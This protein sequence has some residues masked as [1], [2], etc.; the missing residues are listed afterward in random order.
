MENAANES[1]WMLE[2]VT[3][4]DRLTILTDGSRQV[5]D[6]VAADFKEMIMRRCRREPFQYIVGEQQ[7]CG[8][9]FKVTPA[10]LIPRFE[11]E[12]L[13]EYLASKLGE[14]SVGKLL[15]IGTG[16][17]CIPI[18]LL[19]RLEKWTGVTVDLSE[20]A[21]EV[22]RKNM[23]L[24]LE[25]GQLLLLHGDCFEP[26]EE[27]DYDLIVSNPPYIEREELQN[28]SREVTGYEP[29]MAL[30]G[31]EDGL[32]FY[33]KIIVEGRGY[34]KKGGLLAFEIGYNQK[35]PVEA[36]LE[37]AGY[38]EIETLKDL[39]GQDRMVLAVW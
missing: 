39:Y 21:L 33:R 29:H 31:G 9:T 1:I 28:L 6:E 4:W 15:E 20:E 5:D 12:E 11:T 19:H 8:L 37:K 38:T 18:T 3:G 13:V 35:A 34:L 7:F 26:V 14:S 30:D 36:L 17:G 24:H 2:A 16:S 25:P 10:V 32:D 27:T 23:E 22:A